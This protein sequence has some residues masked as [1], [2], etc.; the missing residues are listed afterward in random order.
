LARRTD[1]V[2]RSPMEEVDD[3]GSNVAR[4]RQRSSIEAMV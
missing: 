4:R 1:A 3:L 2:I